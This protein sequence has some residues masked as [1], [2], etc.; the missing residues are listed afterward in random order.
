LPTGDSLSTDIWFILLPVRRRRWRFSGKKR[1]SSISSSATWFL[2]TKAGL[3]W[4][5]RPDTK[6]AFASGYSADKEDW[7]VIHEEGHPFLQKPYSLS[8]LL[9][10][11]REVL[12]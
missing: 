5:N 12:G 4:R 9:K 8:D 2:R 6:V 1:E 7:H 11:V 3:G 10:V